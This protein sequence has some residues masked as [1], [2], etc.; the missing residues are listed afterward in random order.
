MRFESV[1]FDRDG[2]LYD[3]LE[4]I[5]QA[6]AYG[7]EPFVEKLPTRDEMIRAFGPAEP[8]VLA[9]FIPIEKKQAAFNRFYDYYRKHFSQIHFYPGIRELLFRL[10]ENGAKLMLFTG[11]GRVSTYFCLEQTGILHLFDALICGEDVQRPKPD[12]EG[13][14]KLIQEQHLD[15]KRS[16]VVGDAAS[17]VEAGKAAGISAAWLRWS[18]NAQAIQPKVQPDYVCDSIKDLEQVLLKEEKS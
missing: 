7:V 4:I 5:L 10:K 13:I 12:P 15:L 6:F 18:I 1:I 14:L 16:I 9:K 17:D 2:T 3:S 8:E 11:G